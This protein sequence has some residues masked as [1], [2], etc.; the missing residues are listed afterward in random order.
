[1]EAY[2]CLLDSYESFETLQNSSKFHPQFKKVKPSGIEPPTSCSEAQYYIHY[3]VL[4][5]LESVLLKRGVL[6]HVM[7]FG[8]KFK[9]Y[10]RNE[11][12][13]SKS[14]IWQI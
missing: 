6:I 13:N 2:N 12:Q 10:S 1:M 5:S 4:T 14:E 8:G 7:S 3:S 11:N 9:W